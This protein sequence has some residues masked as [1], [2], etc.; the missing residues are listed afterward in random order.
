MHELARAARDREAAAR[1]TRIEYQQKQLDNNAELA[2]TVQ[3]LMNKKEE[4]DEL[5]KAIYGLDITIKTLGRVKT[6]FLNAK[7]F[8]IGVK[9]H[10]ESLAAT[11]EEL[12][13]YAEEEELRDEYVKA[14]VESGYSWLTVAKI[15]RQSALTIRK[16]D[17]GV[18][19]VMND[20]PTKAEAKLLIESL[21]AQ[22]IAGIIDENND[23]KKEIESPHNKLPLPDTVELPITDPSLPNWVK[24]KTKKG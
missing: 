6:I 21:G 24:S 7:V 11:P 8:W 18:D 2:S 16:V 14:V 15:C 20:L 23:I 9:K 19:E 10:V 13:D 1:T 12:E 17:A 3:K 4:K 22:I 5:E